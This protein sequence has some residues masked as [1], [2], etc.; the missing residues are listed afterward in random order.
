MIAL[1][2]QWVSTSVW[3]PNSNFSKSSPVFT[4]LVTSVMASEATPP[5]RAH[6]VVTRDPENA[7]KNTHYKIS[8][9]RDACS[10]L[11]GM[12]T[13]SWFTLSIWLSWQP[14]DSPEAGQSISRASSDA[15]P[16]LQGHAI[17]HVARIRPTW[18]LCNPDLSSNHLLVL[19]CIVTLWESTYTSL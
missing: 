16:I 19:Q 15:R 4:K 5:E 14:D 13:D 2:R 7:V 12:R 8:I 11:L 17:C 3:V 1:F 9:A 10:S 18:P 6:A